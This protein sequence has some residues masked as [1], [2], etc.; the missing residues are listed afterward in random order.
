MF[1]KI[2]FMTMKMK[3]DK[4][5]KTAFDLKYIRKDYKINI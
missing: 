5:G 2:Y 3:M 1:Y 4:T